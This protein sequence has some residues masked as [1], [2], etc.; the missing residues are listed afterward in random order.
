[1]VANRPTSPK[2]TVAVSSPS[3]KAY[4]SSKVAKE[5]EGLGAVSVLES[6]SDTRFKSNASISALRTP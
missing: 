6:R 2:K 3:K 1:M 5:P 4:I